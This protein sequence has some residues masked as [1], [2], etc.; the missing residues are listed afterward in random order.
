MPDK[1]TNL[2]DTLRRGCN[3][4]QEQ[5]NVAVFGTRLVSRAPLFATASKGPGCPLR[6]GG[7]LN[8]LERFTSSTRKFCLC[9]SEK[10]PRDASGNKVSPGLP[11][12]KLLAKL[13]QHVQAP[14]PTVHVTPAEWTR[15]AMRVDVEISPYVSYDVM[16]AVAGR[17]A[18]R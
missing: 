15:Y 2:G 6:I 17:E 13:R 4:K 7:S 10:D 11:S 8:P 18:L 14:Y 5:P 16:E 1:S 3:N 12:S 9:R